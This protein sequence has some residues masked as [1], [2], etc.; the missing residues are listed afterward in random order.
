VLAQARAQLALGDA[1]LAARTFD[2]AYNLDPAPEAL[3]GLALCHEKRRDPEGARAVLAT[4]VERHGRPRGALAKEY[5]A[6]M[7]RL[8]GGR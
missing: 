5:D 3:L 8:A 1:A 6:L 7:E 2:A 4:L